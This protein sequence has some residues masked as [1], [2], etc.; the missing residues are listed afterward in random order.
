MMNKAIMLLVAFTSI[1]AAAPV[2]AQEPPHAHG[3]HAHRLGTVDFP[4]SGSPAA[5]EPFLR[6]IALLHSFEYE[7]AADAFHEAQA[8]DSAFALAWWMEA[9]TNTQLLWGWDDA[10]AA[11]RALARLGLTPEARLAQAATPRERAY[12]AAVEAFYADT[13]VR[14]RAR[15]FADSL[16]ALAAREPQD[17]EA[18]AFASVA[19]QMA[20]EVGAFPGDD[21]IAAREDAITLAERVFQANRDHPG[22]AHYLIHVY[23]NPDVA[24]RGL[25]V[26]RA[27]ALIAPDAQHALHM[28]SHIFV[29]VG[30]WDDVVASNER[31]WAA[32]RG[33]A[34]RRGESA[35]MLDFHAFEWL[36]HGYLQQGRFEAARALIDTVRAV[37][38]GVD[39]AESVNA[40]FVEARLMFRYAAETGR[41]QEPLARA[42]GRGS[43]AAADRYAFFSLFE[44]YQAA[45]G[46]ILQGDTAAPA[47]DAFRQVIAERSSRDTSGGGRESRG[48][49]GMLPLHVS[50]LRACARGDRESA[51]S[52]L[53]RAAVFERD[54]PPVGPPSALPTLELLG[55]LLLEIDR[56]ADAADAYERALLRLPNRSASLLGLARARAALGDEPGAA[57]RYRQLLANWHSADPDLPELVEARRFLTSLP[58]K[59]AA[60]RTPCVATAGLEA[61]NER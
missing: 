45:V 48:Y 46:A 14:T 20:G 58:A 22:A 27:Y 53:T 39:R 6:G 34:A 40:T 38:A 32:T 21:W 28:P 11:R 3:E 1:G 18:A 31:A 8:A 47:I 43:E 7:D 26:A 55:A 61:A 23:D 57:E 4:N 42:A 15:A 17:M 13:D 41:W 10:P 51:I 60:L 19:L 36:Q 56:P 5:Q 24:A 33:W 44:A 29:Q 30:L 12:G 37:L 9:L 52:L 2:R 25:D 49:L 59:A 35:A 54:I 16:R 50:A